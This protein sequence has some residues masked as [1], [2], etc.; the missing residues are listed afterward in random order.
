MMSGEARRSEFRGEGSGVRGNAPGSCNSHKYCPS[1]L[2]PLSPEFRL[3]PLTG[4][5]LR[6]EGKTERHTYE[7]DPLP[8][9]PGHPRSL[10]QLEPHAVRNNDQSESADGSGA[11]ADAG[12]ARVRSDRAR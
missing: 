3:E 8:R 7:K 12:R 1:P 5:P 9:L 10:L 4:H 6:G 11:E 2:D